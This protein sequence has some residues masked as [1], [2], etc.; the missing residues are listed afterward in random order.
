MSPQFPGHGDGAGAAAESGGDPASQRTE[1]SILEEAKEALFRQGNA[2]AAWSLLE[3]LLRMNPNHVEGLHTMSLICIQRGHFAQAIEVIQRVLPFLPDNPVLLLNMGISLMGLGRQEE[4][5][6]CFTEL[7]RVKPDHTQAYCHMG[8]ILILQKKESDAVVHLQKALEY[9]PAYTLAHELLAA[10]L[11]TMKILP[12]ASYHERLAWHYGKSGTDPNSLPPKHTFFL[13]PNK[14]LRVARQNNMIPETIQT[15]G[16]QICYYLGTPPVD[17]PANFISVPQ[18]QQTLVAF[19]RDQTLS[20][21]TAIDFNPDSADER[22]LAGRIARLLHNAR[23][24]RTQ[25]IAQLEVQ[26]QESRPEFI[27]G[28][29]L[30][31]FLPASRKTDVMYHNT[32]DLNQAFRRLGCETRFCVEANNMQTFDFNHFLQEQA[33]FNPHLV[34]DINNYFN[35]KS[36]PDVFKAAWMT[37]PMPAVMRGNP[38]PWRP[39]DLVYSYSGELDPFL[40]RTGVREVM[41]QG[42]CHDEEI[43]RY[44]GQPKKRKAVVIASAHRFIFGQF[45]KCKPLLAHLE[46][47]FEAGEP[48]T[49]ERLLQLEAAFQHSKEDILFYLWSYVV[50]NQSVRWLCELS[51][52]IEVEVYGRQWESDAV[53]RPFFKGPL[54]HGPAVAAVYDEAMYAIVSQPNYLLS[55]RLVETGACGAIPVIYDCRHRVE[56]FPWNE[57]CLWYRT[58]EEMR[59]CLTR[60]PPQSPLL[61]AEGNRY[62]D[63]AKRILADMER[64]LARERVQGPTA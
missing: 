6:Q 9:N 32:R 37:D 16:L 59:A 47:L 28:Q 52:T 7:V 61:I 5:L 35:L 1:A 41:R 38:L 45:P 49:D 56:P 3:Q 2:D 57:H 34:I 42:Y 30:R 46:E 23:L 63:F 31:V 8:R 40:Y 11:R 20:L 64:Q 25:K 50:R 36:H 39:R 14:A 13:D 60:Q 26:C 55:Q 12:L 19:F 4:A 62:T 44:S 27:A 10:A 22:L 53:V 29:P 17:A 51:D 48:M 58:R 43:F 33:D 54:P 18:E 15:S 21:P 24:A